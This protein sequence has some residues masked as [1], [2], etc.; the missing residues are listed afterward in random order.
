MDRLA[1]VLKW[2][3]KNPPQLQPAYVAHRKR[4]TKYQ[5]GYQKARAKVDPEFALLMKCRGRLGCALRAQGVRKSVRTLRLLGCTTSELKRHLESLW[6][7]GMCWENYGKW[8]IDHILPCASFDLLQVSEQ[9]K[10]FHYTNL[11]PL[12]AVDNHRKGARVT[13]PPQPL[14]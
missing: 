14:A 11:Q 5:A 4:V 6:L 10:C 9:R 2:E 13:P 12:W 8:H 7:P 1:H 3:E